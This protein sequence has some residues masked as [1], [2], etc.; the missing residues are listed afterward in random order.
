M[1]SSAT[2]HSTTP[3]HQPSHQPTSGDDD[4]PA[5]DAQAIDAPAADLP[6]VADLNRLLRYDCWAN[7]KLAERIDDDTPGKALS[8]LAHVLG[9]HRLWQARLRGEA[10]SGTW[11]Q[12]MWPVPKPSKFKSE[13]DTIR[14]EWADLLASRQA[15]DRVEYK[16]LSGQT[17]STRVG[18]A[19]VHLALHGSFHRG[20][21]SMLIGSHSQPAPNTGLVHA[22]HD[23]G[24]DQ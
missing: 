3:Q 19:I 17:R 5:F 18:D 10:M 20:Q 23:G 1:T 11:Q 24:L 6:H 22:I 21:V 14:H 8:L 15:D 4:V 13:C 16:D 2:P 9:M 7:C 12:A